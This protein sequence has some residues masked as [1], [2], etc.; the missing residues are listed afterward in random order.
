MGAVPTPTPS[1]FEVRRAE[2][3][4]LH[5]GEGYDARAS[6]SM[7]FIAARPAPRRLTRVRDLSEH[8]LLEHPA[9]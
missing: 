3:C 9:R 7:T 5:V 1:Q 2:T 8:Q 6:A 4:S